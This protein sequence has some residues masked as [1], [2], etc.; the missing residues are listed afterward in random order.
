MISNMNIASITSGI[1]GMRT[2]LQRHPALGVGRNNL[3][4]KK[5]RKEARAERK[6][7]ILA[8]RNQ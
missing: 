5:K 1:Q 3:T 8:L 4:I 6:K 2:V 7:K